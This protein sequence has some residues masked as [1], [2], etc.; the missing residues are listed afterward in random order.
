MANTAGQ[1]RIPL[2]V[3]ASG[4]RQF[5]AIPRVEGS[6]HRRQRSPGLI[7]RSKDGEAARSLHLRPQLLCA[8]C[9][10]LCGG[11]SHHSHG[12]VQIREWKSCRGT[13]R[14]QRDRCDSIPD[15]RLPALDSFSGMTA[16]TTAEKGRGKW[17]ATQT[18]VEGRMC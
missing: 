18:S 1:Y 3:Q 7:A 6:P 14:G 4:E 9:I 5:P 13:G 10:Q 12:L 15:T 11:R 2:P 16:G 17:V 8:V